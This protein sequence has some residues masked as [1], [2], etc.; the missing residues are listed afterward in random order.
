MEFEGTY[1]VNRWGFPATYR[2]VEKFQATNGAKYETSYVSKPL[3]PLLVIANIVLLMSFLVAL[4]APVT[5]FWRPKKLSVP[6]VKKSSETK[7]TEEKMVSQAK[8]DANIR[9]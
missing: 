8:K 7:L 2:E 6:D 9:D 1:S 4:L 5:I 3:N